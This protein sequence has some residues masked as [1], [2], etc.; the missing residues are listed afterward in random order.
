MHMSLE[1]PHQDN[2]SQHAMGQCSQWRRVVPSMQCTSAANGGGVVPSMQCTSAANG[3]GV[4]PSMQCTSAANGGGVVPSMQCASAA[5]GGG[6]VPS[7]QFTSAANG[8]GVVPSM[9]C[10]SAA[11]GGG[12]VP[13]MQCARAANGGGVV[14]S[15]QCTSASHG[16]PVPG[17][18]TDAMEPVCLVEPVPSSGAL[19]VNP[20]ALGLLRVLA[21]PLHVLAVF[22]PRGT[23]KSFLLDRLVGQGEGFPRSPGIWVWCLPHPT[24]PD[25]ALVLLDTEGF[26]EQEGEETKLSRL[27]L[28]NV[29]LSSVFVYNTRSEGDP[30][31]QLDRLTYVRDLPRVVHVLDECPWENS[32]LL[33]SVLPDFVWCLR[34]VAPDPCL[35][36][37]LEATDHELDSALSSPQDSEDS[38]SSCVQRFFP[39]RK[40][41]RFC[42]P[43]GDGGQGEPP[44]PAGQ[45]HPLFQEQMGRF[46]DYALSRSPKTVVGNRAV[47]GAFLA[48]FLER[49]VDLLCRDEPV[50][51]SE[52]CSGLQQEGSNDSVGY[53]VDP[54]GGA[55][56]SRAAASTAQPPVPE[57]KR[58]HVVPLQASRPALPVLAKGAPGTAQPGAMEEPM[59]LIE[60]SRDGEL[61]LNQ[62][63]L[64]LLQS[65]RQPV[66]VVAI[67]G[68]YRTG[69]SYLLNRLAGKDRGGFSL[70]ST[71]QSHTKGIWMWCLPHPRR[72]GHTLVLL[73]TEGLSDVG[74]GNTKNDTWIFA[75]AVLLSS[76]LVYNSKGTIDQQAM[77]QLHYVTELTELI[78]VKPAAEG[79]RE[80][81]KVKAVAEGGRGDMEVKAA[82]E[83]GRQEGED[84]T[85]FVRFF[86][87]FVW[88]VRDFTL[89]LELDGREIT[90]DEYLEN[91]LELKPGSSE[92]DQLYNLPRKCIRQFFPG[93][94]CFVFVQPAGRRDLPRLEELR[95]DELDSEFQ[96]QVA[97]FCHHVWETSKPKTI[98]GG[99]VVTGAMLGNLAVTYVDAIRSGV[100]PCMESAVLALA[101]MENLAAVGEAV[102]AYEEQLGRR[103]AL[104]TESVQELLELHA[105]CEREALRA[106]MARAFKDEEQ[107][108]Q[109]QLKDELDSKRAELCRRNEQA[110]SDRCTAAL[111]ELSQE[112]EERVRE[113]GYSVP[114][115]YQRLLDDQREM[116]EKYQLVPEKGIMAAEVLQQFLKS[117]ETVAQAVLQTDQSLTD[118]QREIEVERARAEAAE[119]EAQLSQEMQART[120]QL[121]QD[122]ERSHQ[123]HVQQLTAKME[124]D[125][126]QLLA[127][128]E[129]ALA[130]K[131]QEQERLLRE[132]LRGEVAQLQQQMQ[133]LRKEMSR[134][135]R[136]RC[137]V[138]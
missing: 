28:L 14:P 78:K 109:R 108:Y 56:P 19:R 54:M 138:C 134:P 47:D 5:N 96:E 31:R 26:S 46:K 11:N 17:P 86:P 88:A 85:E 29:L 1:G 70:G 132:G 94:K 107:Q 123:E 126:R 129:T 116:V 77:D 93:R 81:M 50:F 60:N 67:A 27:F 74:K 133:N 111:L 39:C 45:L 59:C 98:P 68:L 58:E 24:Q 48:D 128:Q 37:A 121:L 82:G 90:E 84:S 23:G 55:P 2:N 103:V 64:A 72:A 110:S 62:A 41:F 101:Q 112:L 106:F 51:L 57:P 118:R 127:E 89:Q 33:S 124:Q 120:E 100:V 80:D 66:V 95:E 18:P 7:M 122:Q 79:S 25:Q 76:T 137:V 43:R 105:Q 83:G 91:A 69:K 135:R 63:A 8:G 130:L 42:S 102:A 30:Q 52:I 87:A 71:I 53:P 117:K 44:S 115:G 92:Q 4:V 61:Q 73:D 119:R 113:G 104:P 40:L 22:G 13:S 20:A 125:R 49:I 10:A 6:V 16:A 21:R 131:L 36:E 9:Q 32:F 38:P 34:D 75:L 35:D 15:M 65:V 3:G 114:G 97:R 99:H 12:V 136:S